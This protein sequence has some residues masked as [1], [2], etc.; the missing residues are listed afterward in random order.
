MLCDY[1]SQEPDYVEAAMYGTDAYRNVM[2]LS[3]DPH[4]KDVKQFYKALQNINEIDPDSPYDMEPYA[5][6]G[7]YR[8]ALDI[9]LDR[10]PDNETYKALD[11]EFAKNN[12]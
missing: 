5:V 3:P 8:K 9:L 12:D 2:N 6:S 11:A 7:I 4:T 10:E 1:S